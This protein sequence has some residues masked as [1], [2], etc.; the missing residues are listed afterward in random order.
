MGNSR[1]VYRLTWLAVALLLGHHLEHPIRHDAVGRWLE[2]GSRA[3]PA[4]G[5]ALG[6]DRVIGDLGTMATLPRPCQGPSRC[7]ITSGHLPADQE[8][9]GACAD[10]PSQH[11]P[12]GS[13]VV[14]MR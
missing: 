2:S 5:V 9:L 10:L 3:G 7:D 14:T 12:A 4:R 6:H 13:G 1:I 11:P 8:G